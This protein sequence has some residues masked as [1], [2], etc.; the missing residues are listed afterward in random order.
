M[1]IWVLF[2]FYQVHDVLFILF[3]EGLEYLEILL[4]ICVILA[5]LQSA[6]LKALLILLALFLE[7]VN[8]Q[9]KLNSSY[10]SGSVSI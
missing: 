2:I 6:V 9:Y 10:A 8:S 1:F 5:N 3:F 4:E 7:T